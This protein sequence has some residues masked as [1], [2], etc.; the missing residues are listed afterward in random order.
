MWASGLWAGSER[1][2]FFSFTR[3]ISNPGYCF[4]CRFNE[5]NPQEVPGMVAG[6][7]AETCILNSGFLPRSL[8]LS[9]RLT[10]CILFSVY[11]IAPDSIPRKCQLFPRSEGWCWKSFDEIPN[12]YFWT[13]H[14]R[15]ICFSTVHNP[16]AV[17][18][19]EIIQSWSWN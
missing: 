2:A 19:Y 7:S 16:N 17:T 3:L 4:R 11:F 8:F 13:T 10:L 12:S 18:F 5:R 15:R 14:T 9:S 1:R 6:T